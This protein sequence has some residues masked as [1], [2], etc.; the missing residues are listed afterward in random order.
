MPALQCVRLERHESR[1][2][3]DGLLQNESALVTV[4]ECVLHMA[5]EVEA[6][7]FVADAFGIVQCHR[8]RSEESA[9]HHL[10]GVVDIGA[11]H[12]RAQRRVPKTGRD[13]EIARLFLQLDVE[14]GRHAGAMSLQLEGMLEFLKICVE[15]TKLAL[16][17]G[18][19]RDDRV[20][21]HVPALTRRRAPSSN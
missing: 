19:K 3:Q 5:Q 12:H 4:D 6:H 20:Q 18:G 21:T 17:G 8:A 14:R 11:L 13:T 7:A 16:A 1:L 15:E 2:L 10:K 9:P